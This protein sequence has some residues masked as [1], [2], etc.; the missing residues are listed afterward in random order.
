MLAGPGLYRV[1]M[2]DISVIDDITQTAITLVLLVQSKMFLRA[3]LWPSSVSLVIFHISAKG[4]L[5][6]VFK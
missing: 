6:I 5:V 4:K 1:D 2:V 3:L